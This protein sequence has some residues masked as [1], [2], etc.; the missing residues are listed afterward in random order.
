MDKE[1]ESEALIGDMEDRRQIHWRASTP[2]GVYLTLTRINAV[3]IWLCVHALETTRVTPPV[4]VVAYSPFPRFLLRFQ[5]EPSMASLFVSV[6]LLIMLSISVFTLLLVAKRS[7]GLQKT[8][9]LAVY[10]LSVTVGV[11]FWGSMGMTEAETFAVFIP[12]TMGLGASVGLC[13]HAYVRS[14]NQ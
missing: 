12:L 9:I 5:D 6:V 10:S 4:H 11:L 14:S 3:P 2:V 13:I 8:I 7:F 1:N